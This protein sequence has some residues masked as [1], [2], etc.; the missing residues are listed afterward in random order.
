[1]EGFD[2]EDGELRA[3]ANLV[4]AVTMP[5]VDEWSVFRPAANALANDTLRGWQERDTLVV[6]FVVQQPDGES[7]VA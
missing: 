5:G 1:M 6:A 7:F 2:L 3:R 4:L